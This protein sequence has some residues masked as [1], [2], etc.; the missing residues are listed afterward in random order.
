MFVSTLR[1][2]IIFMPF[3]IINNYMLGYFTVTVLEYL[4][5]A[6]LIGLEVLVIL[7]TL[8]EFSGGCSRDRICPKLGY[9]L[10]NV[11]IL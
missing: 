11:A 9:I 3:V 6:A 8:G 5:F 2:I 1:Q 10:I 7:N 4:G